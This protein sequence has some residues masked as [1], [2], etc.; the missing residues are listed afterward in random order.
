MVVH[1]AMIPRHR[2][3]RRLFS[4]GRQTRHCGDGPA[5]TEA[6]IA[7]RLDNIFG[8]QKS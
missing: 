7:N 3:A 2:S 5:A 4:V 6:V 8:G 1:T